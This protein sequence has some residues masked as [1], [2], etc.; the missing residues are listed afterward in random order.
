MR[1]AG[2]RGPF[3]LAIPLPDLR[4]RAAKSHNATRGLLLGGQRSPSSRFLPEDRILTD[5]GKRRTCSRWLDLRLRR[6]LTQQRRCV[7]RSPRVITFFRGGEPCWLFAKKAGGGRQGLAP[8]FPVLG[9]LSGGVAS[10]IAPLVHAGKQGQC[11]LRR[12]DFRRWPSRCQA[13]NFNYS[14][15]GVCAAQ[16]R[17]PLRATHLSAVAGLDRA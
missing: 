10:C 4:V 14:A 3:L 1:N 12:G 9:K 2:T 16:P 6:P 11:A 13:I 7:G 5:R 15:R 8:M 17:N